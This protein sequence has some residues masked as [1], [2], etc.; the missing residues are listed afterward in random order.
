MFGEALKLYLK[1]PA[2]MEYWAGKDKGEIDKTLVSEIAEEEGDAFLNA[3][4]ETYELAN[5]QFKDSI[6]GPLQEALN[7]VAG[8]E[9]ITLSRPRRKDRIADQ[10]LEWRVRSKNN[11]GEG[12]RSIGCRF[13]AE[14]SGDE[15]VLNIYPWVWTRGGRAGAQRLA[16]RLGDGW[17]VCDADG[18][19]SSTIKHEPRISIKPESKSEVVVESIAGCLVPQ[20]RLLAQEATHPTH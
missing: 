10:S 2:E 16:E 20:M 1:Y 6:V 7:S 17:C 3:L 4:D 12:Y 11:K 15:S 5:K 19:D 18:W 9:G 14:R 13:R 8:K